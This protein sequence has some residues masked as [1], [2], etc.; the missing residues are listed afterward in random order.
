MPHTIKPNPDIL[1]AMELWQLRAFEQGDEATGTM[2]SDIR[3]GYMAGYVGHGNASVAIAAARERLSTNQ[4]ADEFAPGECEGHSCCTAKLHVHG[5]FADR[6][7]SR[8]DDPTEHTDG[9]AT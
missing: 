8:C 6:D 9:S 4:R 1:D 5:C 7:G 3:D 2:L